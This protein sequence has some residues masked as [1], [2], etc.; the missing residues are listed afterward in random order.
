MAFQPKFLAS[1]G[2]KLRRLVEQIKPVLWIYMR[3]NEKIFQ[4]YECCWLISDNWDCD[5][6][7]EFE[8]HQ[9]NWSTLKSNIENAASSQVSGYRDFVVVIDKNCQ[10][11]RV[12]TS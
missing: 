11:H 8:K 3:L 1:I 12:R 7:N 6:K 4:N 2:F 10:N 5:L 9:T